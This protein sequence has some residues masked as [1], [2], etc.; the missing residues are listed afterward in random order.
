MPKSMLFFIAVLIVALGARSVLAGDGRD[1]VGETTVLTLP[2]VGI[3]AM[4]DLC[5]ADFPGARICKSSDIIRNGG[6]MGATVPA[7]AAWFIPSPVAVDSSGHVLD[8]SG[9][10]PTILVGDY[11]CDLWTSESF[12][13]AG[14][15]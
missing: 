2:N 7:T 10:A 4:H 5:D 9:A 14:C 3:I 12:T 8:S 1:Y 15:C 11:T 13:P 6:G